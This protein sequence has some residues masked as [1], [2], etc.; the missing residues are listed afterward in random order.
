M[1]DIFIQIS[2]IPGGSFNASYPGWIEAVSF[3]W[4]VDQPSLGF[5]GRL[6]SAT[7]SPDPGNFVF[8]APASIASP[9]L[10]AAC[11]QGS[12]ISEVNVEITRTVDGR[13]R[14][15]LQ[16]TL[17]EVY[18]KGYQSSAGHLNPLRLPD[19]TNPGS[20]PV[21]VVRLAPSVVQMTFNPM[22]AT[23]AP[24]TKVTAGYDFTQNQPK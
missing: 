6:S 19:G 23:G 11:A 5:V 22:T 2:G 12:A 10:F 20:D 17:T 3:S 21:D 18:I 7:G 9:R 15:F 1:A 13:P 24:G 4:G 16:W 14:A 8:V